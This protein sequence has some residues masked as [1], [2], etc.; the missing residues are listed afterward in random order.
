MLKKS[1]IR[2]SPFKKV[3]HIQG[4]VSSL[5]F[6]PRIFDVIIAE[7]DV[8]SYC[9]QPEMA[10]EEIYKAL[11]VGGFLHMS[12][13]SL[14]T[15]IKSSIISNEIDETQHIFESGVFSFSV[16]DLTLHSHAFTPESLCN[17]LEKTGF[18]INS[19][20]GN[21]IIT[22]LLS[23]EKRESILSD[24]KECMKLLKL[25]EKLSKCQS[26]IGNSIHIE[27]TAQ[28]VV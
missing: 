7:L 1:R 12:V 3:Y 26:F 11:K 8:I 16:D 19:I 10:L 13:D 23:P 14:F 5:P 25:E 4:D 28:K 6:K 22:H 18:S 20:Q 27:V 15:V 21:P 2:L 24:E 17:I 9:T